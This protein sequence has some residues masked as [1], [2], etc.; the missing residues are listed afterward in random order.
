MFRRILYRGPTLQALHRDYA[1]QGRIDEA[2]PITTSSAILI[3]A[4]V[5]RVW[6]KLID[7]PAWPTISAAFRDVRLDSKVAV[8]ASFQFTLYNFPIR[9]TFAVV[10]PPRKLLW[11]GGSLW[12]KAIDAH[13]LEATPEG[14]TLY[15][16][17]E[18]FSGILATLF[19]SGEQLAKQHRQWQEWFKQAV[20]RDF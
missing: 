10:D 11:T 12:F 5:E 19:T 20:E 1:K 15:T 4:P 14:Q 6:A 9:A 7:L 8:D 17:A 18:S 2:S 3:D 13:T 16:V